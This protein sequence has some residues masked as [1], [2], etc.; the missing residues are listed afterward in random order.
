[1]DARSLTNKTGDSELLCFLKNETVQLQW[2]EMLKYSEI[3]PTL[4]QCFYFMFVSL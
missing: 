4:T 2:Q 3:H 1:M